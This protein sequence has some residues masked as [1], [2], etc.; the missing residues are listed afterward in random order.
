MVTPL[1]VELAAKFYEARRTLRQLLRE[2]YSKQLLE[3]MEIVVIVAQH[4]QL[5]LLRA[6]IEMVKEC[7]D[8]PL[9]ILKILA[10]ACELIE[11]DEHSPR[12]GPPAETP[13]EG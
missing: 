13:G 10:A 1:Q 12:L 11:P 8:R 9:L 4:R 3:T 2:S 7:E 6:A 5:D